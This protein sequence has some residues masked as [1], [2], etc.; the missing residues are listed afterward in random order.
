MVE[1]PDPD[2]KASDDTG[3]T[4]PSFSSKSKALSWTVLEALSASS[5]I[6]E[7]MATSSLWLELLGVVVGYAPFSKA[8]SSRVG[9]AQTLSRLLWDP[10]TGPS[11]GK[12]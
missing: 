10:V 12:V 2:E 5:K 6:A 11:L 7:Q 9:A 1:R 3:A 4:L 8:W